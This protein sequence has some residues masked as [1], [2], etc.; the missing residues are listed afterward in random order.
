[1]TVLADRDGLVTARPVVLICSST[2]PPSVGHARV[3][4][5]G[6]DRHAQHAGQA[7]RREDLAALPL[8]QAH[9]LHGGGDIRHRDADRLRRRMVSDGFGSTSVICSNAKLPDTARRARTRRCRRR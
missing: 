8:H 6:V 1:M 3:A 4:G 5:I 2:S 9:A 7:V